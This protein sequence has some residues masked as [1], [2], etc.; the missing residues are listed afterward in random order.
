[1]RK[2]RRSVIRPWHGYAAYCPD[3]G[4]CVDLGDGMQAFK[5]A[6]HV[7]EALYGGDGSLRGDTLADLVRELCNCKMPSP[8]RS[9]A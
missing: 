7:R 5:K 6:A 8:E 1:M 3:C 9:G 4:D 2:R